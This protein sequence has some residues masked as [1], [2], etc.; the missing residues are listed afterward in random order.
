[1]DWLKTLSQA[2]P[3]LGTVIGGPVGAIAGKRS[4]FSSNALHR[5]G[6]GQHQIRS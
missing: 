5:E 1:M 2:A 3:L 4:C 6:A